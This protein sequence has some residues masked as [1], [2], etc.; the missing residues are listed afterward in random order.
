[1]AASAMSSGAFTEKEKL[2]VIICLAP[3]NDVVNHAGTF[4][5]I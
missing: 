1:M 4:I 5:G 3:M 2:R